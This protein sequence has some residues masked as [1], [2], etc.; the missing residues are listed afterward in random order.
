MGTTT[1][2][3]EAALD[4]DD[5]AVDAIVDEEVE[6]RGRR[7]VGKGGGGGGAGRQEGVGVDVGGGSHGT[8]GTG[9][10]WRAR[11]QLPLF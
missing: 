8:C 10:R 7:G 4:G 9:G 11:L 6:A 5:E 1:G 3:L 2:A